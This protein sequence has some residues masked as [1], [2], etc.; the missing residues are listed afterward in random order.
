MVRVQRMKAVYD[1]YVDVRKWERLV[2]GRFRWNLMN[3]SRYASELAMYYVSESKGDICYKE[4]VQ[5]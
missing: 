2:R 3:R 4:P 5:I 1:V